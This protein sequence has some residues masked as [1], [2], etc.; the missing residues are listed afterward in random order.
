MSD[1][2]EIQAQSRELALI[3]EAVSPKSIS[4]P[5]DSHLHII[6]DGELKV[7]ATIKDQWQA[8][9]ALTALG[10]LLSSLPGAIPA[11]RAVWMQS[12]AT[13]DSVCWLIVATV[14]L[15]ITIVCGINGIRSRSRIEQFVEDI[16][17]RKN[18]LPLVPRGTDESIAIGASGANI[19]R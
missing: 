3:S 18:T 8:G 10:A 4:Y 7:L 19:G 12:L 6:T 2:P 16:R 13:Y 5:D 14:C 9:L 15:V 11:I 17:S 1:L